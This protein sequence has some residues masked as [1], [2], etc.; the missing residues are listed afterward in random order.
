MALGTLFIISAPSG[1]GKTS[2]VSALLDRLDNLQVSISYTTRKARPGEKDGVNYHF[3]SCE[4]FELMVENQQFV[5]HAKVHSNFYGTS[6]NWLENSLKQG[7]DVILEIDW[8]GAEQVR[9]KFPRSKSIFILPPSQQAL[10]ERLKGRG[11][12]EDAIIKQ[13]VA[14]A[15]EEM[16]HYNDADYL[17][18][19]DQFEVACQ[20]LQTIIQA[21]RCE[22]NSQRHEKLLIDLLS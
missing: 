10:F 8:Q 6:Q 3:V 11:Q 5:E 19:N 18:I 20:E 7:I 22:I 4:Q 13:R 9:S 16:S 14:A 21:Q 12:D 17:V 1:A 2:L 15:K